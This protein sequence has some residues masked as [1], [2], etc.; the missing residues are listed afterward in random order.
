[1]NKCSECIYGDNGDCYK[2]FSDKCLSLNHEHFVSK[3]KVARIDRLLSQ[4]EEA[5]YALKI[6]TEAQQRRIV[7]LEKELAELGQ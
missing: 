5:K 7:T 6:Y 4:L 2:T 1:M 3:E